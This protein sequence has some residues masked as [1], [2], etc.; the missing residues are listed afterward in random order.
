MFFSIPVATSPTVICGVF[1]L[2]VWIISGKF[3]RDIRIWWKSD[4]KLPIMILIILPWIGLV[5]T[6]L[7]DDGFRVA[8]KTHYWFYALAIA[9]I[10]AVQRQPDLI[11]K[12]YLSGLSLNSA[13]SILQFAGVVPL[14]NGLTTGL[15]GG[16]SAHITYSL[17]L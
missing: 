8:M 17:L 10:V 13:I 12:M 5:Y 7:P 6:P 1:V 15:L 4:I 9:P 14:K 3:L 2:S 16:S 11:I